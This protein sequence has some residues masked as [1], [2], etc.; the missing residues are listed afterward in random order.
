KYERPN[1]LRYR[2]NRLDEPAPDAEMKDQGTPL[3]LPVRDDLRDGRLPLT[4][5]HTFDGPGSHLVSLIVEPDRPERKKDKTLIG[6]PIKDRIPADNRQDFAV[7][8]PLVP[9]LLVDGLPPRSK[10]QGADFLQVA[11]APTAQKTW[12]VR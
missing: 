7:M 2:I 3:P 1:S 5:T 4:F 8:L 6:E 9:V 12:L 11:L 10:R